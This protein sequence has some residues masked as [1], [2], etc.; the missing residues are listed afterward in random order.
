[1]SSNKTAY[2]VLWVL[3]S[4]PALTIMELVRAT[5]SSRQCVRG[6]LERGL[7]MGIIDR[8]QR[9][10]LDANGAFKPL[11]CY[12]LR[13]YPWEIEKRPRAEFDPLEG[14]IINFL[15]SH[16]ESHLGEICSAIP[17]H[18]RRTV[19]KRLTSLLSRKIVAY[20]TDD[21]ALTFKPGQVLLRNVRTYSLA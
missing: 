4:H 21:R 16:P 9:K 7:Q 10:V 20:S 8:Q 2:N 15:Y 18:D 14:K 19:H 12:S 17:E 11:W 1:M 13:K 3:S 5:G 6:A